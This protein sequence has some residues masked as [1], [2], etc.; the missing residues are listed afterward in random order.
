MYML[1]MAGHPKVCGRDRKA[2]APDE[3][4]D[5]VFSVPA[6]LLPTKAAV[7]QRRFLEGHATPGAGSEDSGKVRLV[8][9][10]RDA[11]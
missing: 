6:G 5:A 4:P 7:D 1:K 2:R 10:D 8:G 3:E 9:G 11:G